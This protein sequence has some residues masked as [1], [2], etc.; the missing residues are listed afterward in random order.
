MPMSNV[1]N[2]SVRLSPEI[3]AEVK[4]L[5]SSRGRSFN[6]YVAWLITQALEHEADLTA[7]KLEG[8]QDPLAEPADV[9]RSNFLGTPPQNSCGS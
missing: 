4:A 7:R 8:P 9:S 3:H 6:S 2:T 1:V 5:A